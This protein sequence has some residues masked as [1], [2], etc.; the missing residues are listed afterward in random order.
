[1]RAGREPIKVIKNLL[2]S[3]KLRISF[4]TLTILKQRMIAIVAEPLLFVN[5]SRSSSITAAKTTEKSSKFH[6]SL[7]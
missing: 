1:M 6:P 4:I 5:Y 3:L 7:K 2:I